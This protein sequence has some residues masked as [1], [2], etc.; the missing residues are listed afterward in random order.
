[1][2]V[3]RVSQSRSVR[4]VPTGNKAKERKLK[5]TF[6]LRCVSIAA[7]SG[8]SAFLKVWN[9]LRLH[10]Q[11]CDGI[12]HSNDGKT[13]YIHRGI[14]CAASP[15]FKALFTSSLKGGKPE[16]NEVRLDISGH[17]L[18]LILDYA[19]TGHCNVTS[20]NVEHLLPIADQYEILGV[21]RQC[22][23]YLLENLQPENCL[24]IFRFAKQY[25]CHDL[26]DQAHKYICHN[27]KQILQHSPEFE[28]LSAEELQSI[29]CDDEL[30]VHS[31]ELVFKA[32]IKWT[33]ADLKA[34]KQYLSTLI[35]CV[36]YGLM[37]FSF[38][39]D[40]MNKKLILAN[41]VCFH[42]SKIQLYTF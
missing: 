16:I 21:L 2:K 40:V 6:N 18:D 29:L 42:F 32:V 35:H 22:C 14:L 11:L 15:Y 30:N 28:D 41:P 26:E 1:M 31:E 13:S 39:T 9:E 33:E 34:R 5:S 4:V 10:Q 36:R 20:E 17:I 19:Y 8:S 3:C 38:F 23:Q 12:L 37:S 24:G 7:D 25:F 27:F